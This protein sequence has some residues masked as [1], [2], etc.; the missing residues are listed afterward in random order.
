[1]IGGLLAIIKMA[2][3]TTGRKRTPKQTIKLN[4]FLLNAD[5]KRYNEIVSRSSGK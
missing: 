4:N 2:C 1:M 5:R 3:A